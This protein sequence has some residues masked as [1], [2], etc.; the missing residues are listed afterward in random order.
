MLLTLVQPFERAAQL[1]DPYLASGYSKVSA[2]CSTTITQSCPG[3]LVTRNQ[4]ETKL[5]PFSIF[6][7]CQELAL[8]DKKKQTLN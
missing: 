3:A 2:Y 1:N 5:L 6:Y 7:L 8:L 4:H